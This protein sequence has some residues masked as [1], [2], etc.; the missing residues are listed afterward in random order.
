MTGNPFRGRVAARYDEWYETP[1][2]QW[3]DARERDLFLRLAAPRPGET[4]LDVGCGTGRYVQW[5]LASGLEAYGVD[6]SEDM[7][8][9]ARERLAADGD[10][11]RVAVADACWLPF[12]DRAFDLVISVT[13]LEFVAD[14]RRC[15]AEMGRVSRQRVFVGVL[16]RLSALW[17]YQRFKRA[18][19]ALKQAR[20]FTPRDLLRMARTEL[21]GW[22]VRVATALFGLPFSSSVGQAVAALAERLQPSRSPFGAYI[23]LI[24]HR[25][26]PKG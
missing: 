16:N 20:Y 22:R 26:H 24:A 1:W 23:A 10:E 14:P 9:V 4:V 5:L 18:S 17:L 21:P 2:G 25:P 12:S 6:L 13:T 15:L 8:A 11:W 19:G 7:L 3:A